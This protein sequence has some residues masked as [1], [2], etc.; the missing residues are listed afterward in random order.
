MVSTL[1]VTRLLRVADAVG[2][3]GAKANIAPLQT[4]M[5]AILHTGGWGG[6]QS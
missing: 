2:S 4:T 6:G 1:I 3:A 5:A